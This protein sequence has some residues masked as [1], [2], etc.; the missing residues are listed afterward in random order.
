[1][2]GR[3]CQSHKIPLVETLTFPPSYSEEDGETYMADNL[4]GTHRNS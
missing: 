1:M 4:D 2:Y 3:D